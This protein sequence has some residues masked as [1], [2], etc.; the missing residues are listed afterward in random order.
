MTSIA[1]IGCLEA[2]IQGQGA[3]QMQLVASSS[4]FISSSV[5]Q[6][7]GCM[8]AKGGTLDGMQLLSG[9]ISQH[10]PPPILFHLQRLNIIDPMRTY[11]SGLL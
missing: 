7:C 6:A 3:H 1:G 8:L 5:A 10:Q 9:V 11:V 4:L 2:A